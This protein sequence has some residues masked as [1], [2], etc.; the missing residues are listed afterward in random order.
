MSQPSSQAVKKSLTLLLANR[1]AI[2]DAGAQY[3]MDIE[4]QAKRLGHEADRLA[5]D[6]PIETLY[7]YGAI[8]LSGGPESVYDP[9]APQPDPRLFTMH[10]G[11]PP[12]L[13]ICYGEQLINYRMG[14]KVDRLERREDGYTTVQFT[15]ASSIN[16]KLGVTA[17]VIMSHGDT[18]TELAPGFIT[19]AYSDD[20]IAGI[21]NEAER[22]YGVQ[23]HP[24]VSPPDGTEIIRAYLQDVAQLPAVYR[25]SDE[26]FIRD[27]IRE[28]QDFVGQKQ[29]LAFVSGGVDS[30]ALAKLLERA[31]PPAQLY[32]VLVDH[33]FMREG[34]VESAKIMLA[35]SGVNIIVHDAAKTFR[36]A[37][38]FIDGE[39]SLPLDQVSDPEV[40]RKIIG[41]CFITVQAHMAEKLGLN[42]NTYILAMG[43]L[44]T[45]LIESG[46]TVVSD[47]AGT[48]KTHHNDTELV[49]NMRQAGRVLEPWRFIQKDNVRAVGKLLDLKEEIYNRQPFPGPGV[50]IRII[51]GDRPYVTED[52]A[53]IS[54][55]L[56]AHATEEIAVSVL[57]IRT[58]GVQGDGRTYAHL[59]GL[60]GTKD[61]Q[62]LKSLADEIPREVRGVNRVV[63]IFGDSPNIESTTITPTFLTENVIQLQK[64]ID[65]IVNQVLSAHQ[66]DKVLSQVPVI[67]T[68][69]N[70]GQSGKRSVAIRTFKTVNFK[71]GDAA[72]PN[73][74]YPEAVLLEIVAKVLSLPEIAAVLYDLTSKPPATTEWE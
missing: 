29:V 57:P 2:L 73:E 51:C 4:Q 34:E 25:Y 8:I 44:Y 67:L 61:W 41:D 22:L 9:K 12:V 18:V 74:D 60:N 69:L 23:F 20:L 68:G 40:K 30:S 37:T 62:K 14:G 3:S 26:D 7:N 43:S 13:G 11:R 42:P 63:Y 46:S 54:K 71:T 53:H 36:Q 56:S 50:A 1:V 70:F 66:L 59:V 6:T 21:A 47:K 38:T 35:D 19:T 72:L 33:G 10:I 16:G 45:D 39:E 58:V 32:L 27:A 49:R 5:F 64:K 24:E 28:V 17:Q 55:Q 52:T 48:I 31:L 65:T 15:G